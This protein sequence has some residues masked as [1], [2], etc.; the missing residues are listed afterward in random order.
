[1]RTSGT[2]VVEVLLEDCLNQLGEDRVQQAEV[3]ARDEDEAEHHAGE[4]DQGLAIRPLHA[5][6]LGPDCDQELYYARAVPVRLGRLAPAPASDRVA[7]LAGPALGRRRIRVLQLPVL[8]L[9]VGVRLGG[10]N[11]LV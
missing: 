2:S 10:G 3:P 6:E 4:S 9:L 7:R 5:L 11:V 1:M 8:D